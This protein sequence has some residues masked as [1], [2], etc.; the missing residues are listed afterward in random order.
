MEGML[1]S[2]RLS[3]R[4]IMLSFAPDSPRKER[5]SSETPS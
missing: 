2:R 5:G 4:G 3:Q 1:I